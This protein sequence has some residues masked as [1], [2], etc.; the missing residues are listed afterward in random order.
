MGCKATTLK[1]IYTQRY[2]SIVSSSIYSLPLNSII[3]LGTN[4]VDKMS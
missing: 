2:L 3:A 4:K 1:R